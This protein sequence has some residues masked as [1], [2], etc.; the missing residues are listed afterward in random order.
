MCIL[1][2]LAV[3]IVFENH[4]NIR[5]LYFQFWHFP[6]IFVQLIF[7]QLKVTRLVTLFARDFQVFR[8]LPKLTISGFF[9]MNFWPLEMQMQ[10]L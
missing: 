6:Q 3:S 8:N 1:Y 9:L 4:P 7:V 2:L 10:T 5:I